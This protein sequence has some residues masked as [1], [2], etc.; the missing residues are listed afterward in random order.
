MLSER[1]RKRLIIL[2]QNLAHGNVRFVVFEEKVFPKTV[3]IQMG[4]NCVPVKV[5]TL[6]LLY[7]AEFIQ[8]LLSVEKK[9]SHI[10]TCILMT[11]CKLIIQTL[12]I[13]WSECILLNLRWKTRR[14][15]TLLLPTR[16]YNNRLGR[17][18]TSHFSLQQKWPFQLP[19]HT[20]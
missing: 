13:T 11:Y 12:K 20:L 19:S 10:V 15:A 8:S 4:K 14:R 9:T 18:S 3:G 6:L 2:M 17:R 16:I 5:A 1:L 7:E